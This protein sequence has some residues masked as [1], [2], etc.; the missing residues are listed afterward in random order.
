MTALAATSTPLTRTRWSLNAARVSLAA[1]AAFWV[2]LALLHLVR[3][4][5]DPSWRF[6]SEYELGDYG[7][8][9]RAA[10]VCL[11]VGTTGIGIAIMSDT[12]GIS[13]A[14][15]L[16]LL[17]VSASG[18]LLAAVYA[19]SATSHLHDL[20]AMLDNIPFAA[21]FIAWKLSK[22][23]QTSRI[24]SNLFA[25]LPL[26]GL[27]IF[28]ASM[29]WFLPRNGGHPGPTVLVGW[30]NRFLIAT[31]CIWILYM[32]GGVLVRAKTE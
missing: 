25:F 15:G 17:A 19:P 13:G 26:L 27:V 12:R 3:P 6:I 24:T 31:Q 14:F 18:M 7:W 32:A 8:M 5:L 20:G 9:M 2:L 11:A 10:F 21:L 16:F 23:D 22:D 1:T 29:A 30:Q 4:D 28:I